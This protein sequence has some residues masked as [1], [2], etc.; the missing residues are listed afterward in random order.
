MPSGALMIEQGRPLRCPIIHVPTSSKYR[1]R[2]SLVT[3]P[4]PSSGHRTLSGRLRETPITTPS[5]EADDEGLARVD[6]LAGTG[7]ATAVVSE[8]AGRSAS[9]SLAGLS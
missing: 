4:S 3:S 9:T 8:G 6:V 2:S 1:A 5:P 7:S